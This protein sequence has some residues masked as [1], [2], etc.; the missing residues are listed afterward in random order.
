MKRLTQA[1]E[2][3]PY[4]R[5]ASQFHGEAKGV[6]FPENEKE[7]SEFLREANAKKIPVTV[8][9]GKTGLTGAA[10]PQGGW[11]LSTEK[12]SQILEIR[13]SES[14]ARVQPAI[15]LK[16]LNHSL[17]GDSLFYAPD[18]TGPKAFLGGTL[19]TNASGPN[20]FKY[21]ATRPH[22]RRIRMVLADGEILNLRRGQIFATPGGM[23]EIP[24]AN[25][26]IKIQAPRYEWPRVKHAGGYF[27]EPGMDALDLFIGSEGTLGVTTEI[28][29][30]LLSRPRELLAYVVFFKTEEDSWCFANLVRETS[31]K[32]R[33]AKDPQVLETRMIEYFDSGSLEFLRPNH[34]S[35]P[36]EA[37]AC[38]FIEQ[39]STAENKKKFSSEWHRLFENQKGIVGIWEGETRDKQEQ[40]RTF[41]SALPLAVREF[42]EKHGQVKI[43]TDTSVPHER[44]EELML[45]HRRSVEKLGIANLT[46]GHMGE[47]HV[48]LNLLPKNK[49]E[50]EKARA[51]YPELVQKA[52]SL[53]GTFS[54]EHGVGK[55]KRRYLE[56]LF[57]PKA[58]E[59]MKTV[60]RA[61]DPNLILG[62]GNLFEI[63]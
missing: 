25:R 32:N 39:E 45:F 59:E 4:L 1:Q 29:A 28:E 12:L 27:V 36:R 56:Q 46:F 16:D 57:G 10:V 14:W 6:V 62:R 33:K 20:S 2:I 44:F 22:I 24:L 40:F 11:V 54:A 41:R 49:E 18:P 48:H 13:K 37:R 31:L 61:F 7:I 43:G 52:F 50:S 17:E 19:A 42:L 35:I 9:G 8:S 23:I 53:G 26:K 15:Y 5:D 55:M 21:G 34:S 60:K 47:S 63:Q 58:I 38:L 3:E 51:F 30:S